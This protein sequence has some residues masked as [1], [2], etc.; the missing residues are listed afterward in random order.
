MQSEEILDNPVTEAI[1]I[2]ERHETEFA[3]NFLLRK[4]IR[5][6]SYQALNLGSQIRC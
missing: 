3:N 1:K 5:F 2:G 6:K 4:R